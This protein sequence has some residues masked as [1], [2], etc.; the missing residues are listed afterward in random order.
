MMRTNL[1][2]LC[3]CAL[4]LSSA[5]AGEQTSGNAPAGNQPATVANQSTAQPTPQAQDVVTA[6]ADETRIRAGGKGEANV[7]LKIIEGYHVN[8]N[9][10]SDKFYI[11]TEII[12]EPQGGI[13][14]GRPAY[15]PG[16][17]KKFEFSQ[18]PLLVYEGDVS[19][20]LPLTVAADVEKG[21]HN[22]AARIRVQPCNDEACLPPRDVKADISVLV[23]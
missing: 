18:Q 8:A 7:T 12:A 16:E 17:S 9:P 23:E 2:A 5:C 14:P 3:L 19:L 13:K 20:R 4:L 6:T 22:L 11:G 10:P 1:L 15:P 21:R